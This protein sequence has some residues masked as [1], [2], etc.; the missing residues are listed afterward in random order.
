MSHFYQLLSVIVLMII[1]VT[2]NAQTHITVTGK[3]VN[4]EAEPVA[5]VYIVATDENTSQFSTISLDDGSFSISLK[6]GDYTITG[7]YF[8]AV[9]FEQ[10]ISVRENMD[11]G[12]ITVMPLVSLHEVVV[13]AKK[14]LLK[15]VEDKLIF[16]VQNVSGITRYKATDILQYVPRVTADPNGALSVAGQSATLFVD[17]RQLS[18]E[19]ATLFIQSMDAKDIK[20]IEVQTMRNGEQSADILGGVIHIKTMSGRM[21]LSGSMSLYASSPKES[22]YHIF[23]GVNAFY[24]KK[25]WNIYGSYYYSNAYAL[26]YGETMNNYLE[27]GIYHTQTINYTSNLNQNSYKIGSVATLNKNHSIAIEF[28]GNTNN[29][30]NSISNGNIRISENNNPVNTGVLS[31]IYDLN[32][33]FN[34]LAALY[35][36]EIDTLGSTLKLLGNYNHKKQRSDNRFILEYDLLPD[37]NFNEMN[38]NAV[39]ANNLS[40]KGDIRKN[41]ANK[42]SLRTGFY[43]LSSNRISEFDV[44][45]YLSQ[46]IPMSTRWDLTEN[47][48]SGYLG[49]SKTFA[50]NLFLYMS[51]RVENTAIKRITNSSDEDFRSNYTDFFPY[52]F[53]SRQTQGKFSW[54]LSYASSVYRP[55]FSLMNNYSNRISDVLY[56]I[57]NPFLKPH[58]FHVFELTAKYGMHSTKLSYRMIPDMIIE[59]FFVEDS[60]TYH[61]NVNRGTAKTLSLDYSLSGKLTNWWMANLYAY[62]GYTEM[63]E[64]YNRKVLI[65]GVS[66]MANS[67]SFSKVGEFQVLFNY[68]SNSIWGNS[69]NKGNFWVNL[70]YGRS[71]FNN[72]LGL[73]LGINDIFN[74]YRIRSQTQVPGLNYTSYA[75]SMP[76]TLWFR[77]SYNFSTKQKVSKSQLQNENQIIDRL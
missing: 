50:S 4:Q 11:M 19:E 52:I 35:T 14:P 8:G 61:T 45:E 51:L 58:I 29:P 2:G 3:I 37:N 48:S 1:T 6:M 20:Q 64:S 66:T 28:N 24:G 33:N 72:A 71:F 27:S 42:W 62:I 68:Q 25:N 69:F 76:R 49:F 34:N 70:S 32:S 7:H 22:Y 13:S 17:D 9:L 23:P 47:I 67:L 59:Y 36:W 18:P 53:L 56:D 5:S 60:I 73:S 26:H 57:G 55:P 63:P 38:R 21:G 65:H 41:W 39:S 30:K 74:N 75:K 31:T 77:I 40:A 46:K 10:K 54:S 44:E 16:D 15:Q 43:V 12:T